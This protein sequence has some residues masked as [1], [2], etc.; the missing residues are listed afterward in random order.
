V[1]ITTLAASDR[2]TLVTALEIVSQPMPPQP[3]QVEPD[4]RDLLR[5]R[6]PSVTPSGAYHAK[7][8]GATNLAM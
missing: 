5:R 4:H 2:N 8:A 7:S 3:R 6:G 1:E